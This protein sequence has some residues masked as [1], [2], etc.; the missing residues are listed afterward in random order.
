MDIKIVENFNF[1][2]NLYLNGPLF[3]NTLNYKELI[4]QFIEMSLK[5]LD[6]N[7]IISFY[8]FSNNQYMNPKIIVFNNFVYGYLNINDEFNDFINNTQI[9]KNSF[10]LFIT[11]L[12]VLCFNMNMTSY[13]EPLDF[14]LFREIL[15]NL[16]DS[17]IIT[18]MNLDIIFMNTSSEIFLNNMTLQLIIPELNN[19]INKIYKNFTLKTKIN[20]LDYQVQINTITIGHMLYNLFVIRQISSKNC[21]KNL[22]AFL[23]HEL[24]NPLQTITFANQLINDKTQDENLIKYL[25]MINRSS[26]DMKKIINDILDASKIDSNEII[27]DITNIN[28]EELIIE[29]FESIKNVIINK[30]I[31]ITYTIDENV[32][33]ELFTDPTR[34]RQILTNLIL[35]A[36]KYSKPNKKNYINLI[37]KYIS[38]THSVSFN[39]SDTGLGLNE[40]DIK[41]IFVDTFS[42]DK[43]NKEFDSN[44]LGL[45]ICNKIANLLGGLIQIKSDINIGST[46]S[47]IH[48]IKL[49]NSSIIYR[50]NCINI[51]G[52]IL[53]VDD[54]IN[55][56][57]LFKIILDN[58]N[59]KYSTNIISETTNNGSNAIDL[60]SINKYDLIFMDINMCG[61]DGYT[62]TKIIRKTNPNIIIIATTG[63]INTKLIIGNDLY[64]DD[65]LLKPFDDNQMLKCLQ[66]FLKKN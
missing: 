30:N 9:Y 41:K 38:S 46:F 14:N 51:T 13:T 44:G 65:I 47:F 64:F 54:S 35:N 16:D 22:T 5:I 20:T 42:N 3:Y 62:T 50:N 21:N 37:I 23:S 34:L 48:P 11:Y 24:R 39:V 33:Q 31:D 7:N 49:G 40:V 2:Y 8:S 53:I 32:P 25:K 28:I 56:T 1:C 26:Y 66:T 58:F 59:Y 43:F 6:I 12:G 63:N 4:E 19:Y 27:L 17:I 57:N 29:L 61:I 45:Y 36:I 52:H 60:C 10:N 55:N 15:N 18:K